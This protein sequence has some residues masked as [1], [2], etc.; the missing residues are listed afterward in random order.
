MALVHLTALATCALLLVVLRAT[1]NSWRLQRK[2]PPG[3]P[4][5][6]F[7][8]SILQL[9]KV[10]AHLKFTEWTRTYGGLYGFHIGPATAAVVTNR[11]L[12]KELFDKRS[13][14]YSSRPTSHV[15]QNIITGGDHLLVMDYSDNWRLFRKT[16][17][18]HFSASMCEKTHVR[19]LEAEHTQMMRDFLLHPEKHMLHTKRTT[20]SI[21]MSL[22]FGIRTPSWDTPQM[23][24]L[25]EIMELWSQIMETGATPPVDIFPWLHWVPQQWFGHWVD[26]SQAV[27]RGMKRLFLDDVLDLQEKLGLTDN[28]VDFLGGVMMEGG[29]DTGSTMLLVMIQALALHPEIQTRAQAELDAVC[30]EYRSPTWEDFPRLPYINMVVKETMRW[31]P[32]TPLAFPHALSKDDWVND[33]FLPKGTAVFLNVWGLHHDENVFPNPDQFDPSRFEGRYKLAFEYAASSEYMQRD[34]Y[35]YGAGRRLCPGIHLSERNMFLGAAKLLWAFNFEPA[36]DEK[37][38]P[39]PIDADPTTSY[40]EGFLVCPRPYKCNVAP[41]CSAHADT[42]LREFT[43]AESEV[44]SQYATP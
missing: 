34:H 41:R 43:W 22:L 39:I 25:Y 44:L 28:Q 36:R 24:D 4:G 40:T 8:G 14:L 17:N 18:Q 12:V 1:F 38:N 2:L 13:A 30:G 27:A 3:P 26:R 33:Y 9:P 23:Q 6:P 32:V 20:N 10:R 35:I 29:S 42:I 37:G 15:G 5:A 11:A 16:I 19:L 21:I 31:R 7:I